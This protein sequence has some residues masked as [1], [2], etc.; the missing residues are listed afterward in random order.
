M[1][2]YCEEHVIEDKET[3]RQERKPI[4]RTVNGTIEYLKE[5]DRGC[6]I[7]AYML[8]KAIARGLIP[9]R[10]VGAKYIINV[11]D[12]IDYYGA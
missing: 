1:K 4:F 2:E 9:A 7:S 10:Q 6:Q 12:V 3:I 8:R 5:Q 11:N